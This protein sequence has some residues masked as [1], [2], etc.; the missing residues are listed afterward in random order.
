MVDSQ[1]ALLSVVLL[2][3]LAAMA[4]I[5]GFWLAVSLL[6]SFGKKVGYS[7]APLGFARPRGGFLAGI[8]A[9]VAVGVGAVLLSIVVNPLSV[10]VLERLGYSARSTIQKPFMEGLVRWVQESPAAAVPAIVLIVVLF[11]PAVEELVFRGAIFNGLYRLTAL[12]SYRSVGAEHSGDPTSKTIFAC[13]AL[14]S[15]ALF[16]LLHLEPVFLPVLLI[17]AMTLCALFQRSGSLLP[18]FVAHATF[19]SFVATL[20]ILDGLG[21][22]DIPI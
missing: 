11:G 10:F 17:L 21:V 19:N 22:L 14:T 7:L 4:V 5:G 1:D 13:S 16:A 3:S 18:S 6:R 8:G 12:I 15:S 2:D 20:I 9:G